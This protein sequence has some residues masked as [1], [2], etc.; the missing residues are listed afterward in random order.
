MK[1]YCFLL[2]YVLSV[3]QL[4][5]QS[6][7]TYCVDVDF[8]NPKTG[9]ASSYRLDAIVD[10]GVLKRLN[11]PSGGFLDQDDFGEVIFKN[12]HAVAI[13]EGGKSY[14]IKLLPITSDCFTDVDKAVRCIGVTAN[15]L[16]CKNKTDNETGYCRLHTNV[17]KNVIISNEEYYNGKLQKIEKWNSQGEMI[18][19][20]RFYSSVCENKT[21]TFRYDKYMVLI[22]WTMDVIDCDK[23]ITESK[24]EKYYYD[25]KSLIFKATK[26][27]NE[28]INYYEGKLNR[29]KKIIFEAECEDKYCNSYSKT[30]EFNFDNRGNLTNEFC[31]RSYGSDNKVFK[32]NDIGLKV[33]YGH[34]NYDETGNMR[35]DNMRPIIQEYQYNDHGKLVEK[36]LDNE[37]ILYK[38]DAQGYL[39]RELKYTGPDLLSTYEYKNDKYGNW[40]EKK[41]NRPDGSISGERVRVLTYD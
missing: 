13:I 26:S 41:Y 32:Y 24:H 30:I 36:T 10:L 16:L 40:I 38:Y 34:F 19:N 18:S 14:R 2:L 6:G 29:D 33:Y 8:Y 17:H 22:E 7:D 20:K 9:T 25:Y 11:F 5:C 39:V 21:Q 31:K 27:Y 23:K 12:D 15:G 4:A 35:T 37:T 1:F 28:H 3:G